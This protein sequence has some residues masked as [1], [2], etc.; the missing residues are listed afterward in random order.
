[1]NK[2][3][4]PTVGMRGA[5]TLSPPMD[6]LMLV[7]E[8]YTC[9][10]V[11]K[12]SDYIANNEDPQAD[13]YEM[14]GL[15]ADDFKADLAEDMYIMSLQSAS[16]HWVYVPVRFLQ[17]LPDANGVA[18]RTLMIGVSVGAHPV[19]KDMTHVKSEIEDLVVRTL[20]VVPVIKEV[21]TSKSILVPSDKHEEMQ[22]VRSAKTQA[23]LT[24]GAKY[25]GLLTQY[26]QALDTIAD[27]RR[28][29]ALNI[30]HTIK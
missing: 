30:Q 23:T 9:Q 14:Y 22:A 5:Y 2:Y 18:Y 20:G 3:I 27:L 26:Q 16:G 11:R 6:Q 10:A 4:I 1:M 15:T 28:Y 19:N 17:S 21:A 25:R 24:D 7:G 13:I 12:L 29:I 8:E